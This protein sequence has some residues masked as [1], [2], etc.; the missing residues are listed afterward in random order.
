MV[1]VHVRPLRKSFG[2]ASELF[3]FAPSGPSL[4][5]T[6]DE[7]SVEVSFLDGENAA[8]LSAL[9]CAIG[10]ALGLGGV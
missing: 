4:S 10:G 3:F 1:R 9:V 2:I 5:T 7:T 8:T 6:A